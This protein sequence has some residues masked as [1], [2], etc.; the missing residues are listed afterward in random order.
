VF[1]QRYRAYATWQAGYQDWYQLLATLYVRQWHLR[2]VAQIIP[3]Y[4]PSSDNNNVAAYISAVEHAV[5]T[6]RLG[7][8]A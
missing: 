1:L 3:V 5:T 7:E 6:W 2:T 8:V 4:A